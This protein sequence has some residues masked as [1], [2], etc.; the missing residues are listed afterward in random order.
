MSTSVTTHGPAG[1][2][3]FVVLGDSIAYGTG[4]RHVDE[5]VGPRLV[6]ELQREGYDVDLRLLAARGATSRDLAA[7]VR[8]AVSVG[9]DLALIVI[10][11]T[12]SPGWCHPHRPRPHW[13]RR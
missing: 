3:R 1:P 11:R 7:Q 5:A 12:I 13:V 9:T 8:R 2:L 4:A 6:R 10:G